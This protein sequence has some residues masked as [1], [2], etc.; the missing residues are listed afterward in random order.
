M[1]KKAT[2]TNGHSFYISPVGQ[3]GLVQVYHVSPISNR[4]THYS[5]HANSFTNIKVMRDNL[6][7]FHF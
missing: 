6:L 1:T 7:R 4:R 2:H 5:D 3:Y